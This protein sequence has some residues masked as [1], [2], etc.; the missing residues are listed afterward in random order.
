MYDFGLE[1]GSWWN[2]EAEYSNDG[3]VHIE[4]LLPA[5]AIDFSIMS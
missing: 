5:V 3:L 1:I 2:L 4:R